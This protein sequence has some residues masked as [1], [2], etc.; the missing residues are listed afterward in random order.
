MKK[1]L[2]WHALSAA[3]LMTLGMAPALSPQAAAQTPKADFTLIH[4]AWMGGWQWDHVGAA[5]SPM[6]IASAHRI[7]RPMATIQPTRQTSPRQA[8][9]KPLPPAWT[10]PRA[11][12]HWLVIASVALSPAESL[13]LVPTKCKRLVICS[14]SC[15]QMMSRFW[16]QRRMSQLR[17]C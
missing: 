11:S 5:L 12:Q 1:R 8:I 16:M 3:F 7:C 6:V 14:L 9:C 2:I 4:S 10:Q 13:K 15:C 17:R